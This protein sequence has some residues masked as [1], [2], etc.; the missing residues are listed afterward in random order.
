MI[1]TPPILIV[2]CPRTGS[3][4]VAGMINLCGAF[5]G[6]MIGPN[7][8]TPKGM[9]ENREIREKVLK[10]LLRQNGYDPRGQYPLPNPFDFEAQEN[11]RERVEKIM[12]SHGYVDGAWFYKDPKLCL[13]W[14]IWSNAFPKAKWI[15]VRRKTEDIVDSCMRTSFMTAYRDKKILEKV[16]AKTEAGGWSWFVEQHIKRFNEM[17]LAELECATIWS[18]PLIEGNF[19][20][21]P[22]IIDWLG[23]KWNPEVTKFPD[24]K[25]W[26]T[27]R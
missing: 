14:T 19:E 6:N 7:P 2:G 16:G 22:G 5:G 1:K 10:Q 13:Y 26:G 12:I 3:S 20:A 27:R 17:E 11:L 24:K 15:I 8:F 9:F 18:E 25:Y 21:L 4:M 23:L